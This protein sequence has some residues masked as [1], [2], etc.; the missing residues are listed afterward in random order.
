MYFV[1]NF[2]NEI[3]KYYLT[4]PLVISI[5]ILGLISIIF[6]KQIVGWFGEHWTKKALS[7][8]PKNKYKIIN[9]L[10]LSINGITHQIDHVVIS[11][12]GIFSIETKQYNGYITGSKYDKYWVRHFG[13]KKCYYINPIR[14]NYGHCKTIAELLNIDE[15]KIY[16]VVCIPSNAKLKVK[17]DGELV[18]YD[19]IVNKIMAYN[20]EKISNTNELYN[21]LIKS[22]IK[23]KKNKKNNIE[24]IRNNIE[25]KDIDKCPK[26]GGLLV[27]RKGKYGK[28]IGCTNYSKCKYTEKK[29]K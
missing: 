6:Y 18:G 3:L 8:L 2:T 15:S 26:C 25:K 23:G 5:L 22:N 1:S 9:N 13:E 17:H 28:F 19:T 20:E 21:K 7:K 12:Y 11:P 27:E 16:N 24:N 4:S 29:I 14:Q 10:L